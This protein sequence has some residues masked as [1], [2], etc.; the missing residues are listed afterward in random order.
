M[1]IIW[2]KEDSTNSNI[3][4][5]TNIFTQLFLLGNF[6]RIEHLFL[7]FIFSLTK[8]LLTF[9]SHSHGHCF[10]TFQYYIDIFQYWK[11]VLILLN[12][13][14]YR[15]ISIFLPTLR[16]THKA[17]GTRSILLTIIMKPSQY[18]DHVDVDVQ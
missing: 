18:I 11:V 9:S 13:D 7:F 1:G 14:I 10:L 8:S 12:I 3:F 2:R 6:F 4:L 5:A 16:N 15:Y 17:N